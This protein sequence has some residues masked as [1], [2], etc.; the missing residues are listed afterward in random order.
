MRAPYR[1]GARRQ[2]LLCEF[3][4]AFF[5]KSPRHLLEERGPDQLAAMTLG[6]WEFLRR[7]R[8][9]Q[10]NVQVVNPEEEGWSAAVT[11]LR[12]EVGDRPFIVDTIREYLAGQDLAI[13]Q[14]VYPVLRI[15]RDAAG[16]IVGVG[17]D[18]GTLEALTH[19]EVA[20]VNDPARRETCARTCAAA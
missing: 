19:A 8:P 2:P 5:A 1:P 7:A 9:D 20:R 17:G 18:E 13:H 14:Y 12:A 4:R 15:R 10:V 6:A 11:V 16:E 3:A